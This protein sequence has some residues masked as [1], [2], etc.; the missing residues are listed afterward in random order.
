MIHGRTVS[1][2][3][4]GTSFL[5]PRY[6]PGLTR[7]VRNAWIRTLRHS[8]PNNRRH[9]A[10]LTGTAKAAAVEQLRLDHQ[11]DAA[12]PPQNGSEQNRHGGRN[13]D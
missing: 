9:L 7:S 12:P 4:Q 13:Y 6:D 2:R 1:A 11:L 3:S 8:L 5:L 10:G